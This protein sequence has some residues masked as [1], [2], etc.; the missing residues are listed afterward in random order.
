[1]ELA[2]SPRGSYTSYH[3][4]TFY[5]PYLSYLI[6]LPNLETQQVNGISL[7]INTFPSFKC[8]IIKYK[9]TF[10]IPYGFDSNTSN[11]IL[12]GL[13][14]DDNTTH[15]YFVFPGSVV[16]EFLPYADLDV[17]IAA[18]IG[19]TTNNKL[20]C[21]PLAPTFLPITSPKEFLELSFAQLMKNHMT[22][23]DAFP[24][25]RIVVH[26]FSFFWFSFEGWRYI[27]CI[28]GNAMISRINVF[29]RFVRFYISA[30]Q[31]IDSKTIWDAT[32]FRHSIHP[33]YPF[34][35]N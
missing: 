1:V 2:P 29:H 34:W 14:P 18:I 11:I 30:C 6:F 19:T 10:F 3:L 12:I 33:N 27:H 21:I 25:P 28:T 5:G 7:C 9:N 32:A 8:S 22:L 13:H 20:Q 24:S 16:T 35:N 23:N 17:A 4:D 26:N 31:L 15:K